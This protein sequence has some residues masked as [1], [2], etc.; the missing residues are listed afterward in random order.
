V[1]EGEDKILGSVR[2]KK[3]GYLTFSFN[4]WKG[5]CFY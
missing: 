1:R 2:R 4:G 5:K 3:R